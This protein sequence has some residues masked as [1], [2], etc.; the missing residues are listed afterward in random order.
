MGLNTTI[1]INNI[2]DPRMDMA[3]KIEVTERMDQTTTFTIHYSVDICDADV[4]RLKEA[5]LNPGVKLSIMVPEE[6]GLMNCLVKGPLTSQQIHVQN[7]GAGSWMQVGGSDITLEMGR[8]F[9]SK[10]WDN[11]T[12]HL[13]VTTIVTTD[14]QLIPDVKITNSLHTELGHVLVQRNNDLQ[15][16]RRLANR[17]GFHFWVDCNLVGLEVAHFKKPDLNGSPNATLTINQE[18]CNMLD[19]AINWDVERPTAVEN[20][21]IDSTTKNTVNNGSSNS[22]TNNNP[23]EQSLRQIQGSAVR[24]TH[25]AVPSHDGNL[26]G[27]EAVL[28]ESDWFINASCKTTFHKIKKVIHAY[29]I[30]EIVGAGSRHSG[31]YLVSG[32]KHTIDETAHTMEIDLIR[33]VW[34]A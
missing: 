16:I 34:N 30:V 20:K 18:N 28:T 23:R 22:L 1:L 14:Y 26:A 33:N 17:N 15:F 4:A 19:L 25:L 10:I 21:Q 2:P 3:D 11:I 32:V 12:D 7:G 9:K 13:A 29:D 6:N 5:N 31:N 27:S 8:A 24:S